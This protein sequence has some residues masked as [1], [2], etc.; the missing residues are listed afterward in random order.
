MGQKVNPHGLR[1]GIIKDWDAKWYAEKDFA[2]NLVEDV[3]IRK[4]IK[5][6]LYAAGVSKIT[7][8]RTAGRVKV[9]VHTAKP[10]IVIGKNGAAIEELKAELQK[11]TAGKVADSK[12]H[13]VHEFGGNYCDSKCSWCKTSN[14]ATNLKHYYAYS[15]ATKC[16]VCGAAR[17]ASEIGAH[18]YGN[19]VTTTAA[20]CSSTGFETRTCKYCNNQ[21]SHI[22][23]V[24]PNNHSKIVTDKEV[25]AT[26]TSTGL[27]EGSHCEDC[28]AVIVEQKT[29]DKLAHT[30]V[31]DKKVDPTT[32]TTGL[33]EGKHCSVCNAVLVEQEVVPAK[34]I[35]RRHG[36]Y[37]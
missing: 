1:V 20:T 25:A 16:S 19:W 2:D 35:L 37:L 7:I 5:N 8:E 10:G 17:P 27:T 15:C 29:T 24:N 4:F 11:M 30:V 34:G 21:Q 32:T 14:D 6:K 33:T 12:I 31:V 23:Q 28:K 18:T 36:R 3:K 13:V 22:I 26:C 9:N